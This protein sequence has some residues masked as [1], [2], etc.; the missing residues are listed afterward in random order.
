MYLTE[1]YTDSALAD[2]LIKRF[3][4]N[5]RKTVKSSA[6]IKSANIN[7]EYVNKYVQKLKDIYA[8]L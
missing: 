6:T 1:E 2:W 7:D 3:R 4:A 5:I 8:Q